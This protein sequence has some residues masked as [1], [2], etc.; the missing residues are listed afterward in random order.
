MGIS[1]I[2]Q[3]S[4]QPVSLSQMKAHLRVDNTCEDDLIAALIEAATAYAEAYTGRV[5]MA[6]EQ[7]LT[8]D[9]FPR[10]AGDP[11]FLPI[12][13]VRAITSVAYIDTDGAT[14]TWGA[15]KWFLDADDHAPALRPAYGEVWPSTRAI[16]NAAVITLQTGYAAMA[17][18]PGG[19]VPAPVR[20]AI[21]LIAGGFYAQREGGGNDVPMAVGALLSP[22]RLAGF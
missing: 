4:A 19:N 6:R 13:P 11:L 16:A 14:Q 5:F 20:Q 12:A 9:A 15:D 1:T 10:S 17:G 7:N 21:K 2:T 22:Y 18:D 8:I 3:P